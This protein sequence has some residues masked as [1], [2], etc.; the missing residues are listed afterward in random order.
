MIF[1]LNFKYKENQEYFLRTYS[2]WYLKGEGTWEV[3]VD[4]LLDE[5]SLNDAKDES[6]ENAILNYLWLTLD[7]DPDYIE[8][9]K[10]D[11]DSLIKYI[12]KNYEVQS[13]NT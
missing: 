8:F 3:D 5:L 4:D 11:L 7:K 12:K 1:E 9:N 13:K 6:I 2:N 10:E